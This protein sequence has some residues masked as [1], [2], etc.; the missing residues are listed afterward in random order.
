MDERFLEDEGLFEELEAAETELLDDYAQGT[1]T[2]EERTRFERL[3]A[4]SPRLTNRLA[5]AR[6]LHR[7]LEGSGAA[8]ARVFDPPRDRPVAPRWL[9][10]AAVA[11][12]AIGGT[13]LVLTS[14]RGEV[15]PTTAGVASVTFELTRTVRGVG[16]GNDFVLPTEAREVVLTV[17]PLSTGEPPRAVVQNLSGAEVWSGT[18]APQGERLFI[19]APAASLKRG[20][21]LLVLSSPTA[22]HEVL[23]E[24][25]FRIR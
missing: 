23:A 20:D 18:A 13:W 14:E 1:L 6:D 9:L 10:A 16:G 19:R 15:D 8:S 3:L 11:L 2:G 7:R 4:A 17:P 5:I 21:Y 22:P 24:Y 12:L 25:A